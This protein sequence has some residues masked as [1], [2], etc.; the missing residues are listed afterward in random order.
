MADVIEASVDLATARALADAACPKYPLLV[1]AL[2]DE[3]ERLREQVA[4][5]SQ[6]DAVVL[7]NARLRARL[8]EIG[9]RPPN[10]AL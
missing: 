9:D 4:D 3:L 10:E 5:L 2:C 6:G 8:A 1:P 7:E